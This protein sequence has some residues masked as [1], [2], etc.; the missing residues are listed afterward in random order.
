MAI[1]D[2]ILVVLPGLP[3]EAA[4]TISWRLRYL[5]EQDLLKKEL[6]EKAELI[7]EVACFP[8]DGCTG[9]EL[10]KRVCA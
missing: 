4:V 10:L 2:T 8:E 1:G 3:K 6:P 9:S 7:S 5:V